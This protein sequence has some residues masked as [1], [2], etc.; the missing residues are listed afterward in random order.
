MYVYTSFKIANIAIDA[1]D[2][3]IAAKV[4]CITCLIECN[5]CNIN[6]IYKIYRNANISRY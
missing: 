2:V 3:N 1:M 6:N 4:L 5:K